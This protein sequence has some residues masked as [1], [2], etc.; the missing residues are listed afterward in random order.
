MVVLRRAL[1][2]VAVFVP[3]A[4]A[5]ADAASLAGHWEGAIHAPVE[6]VA[7]AVD[8]AADASGTL[9]GTFSNPAQKLNGYPLFSASSDGEVV[10]LELK[11]AG[12]GVQ[13]FAGRLSTDGE[14]ITGEFLID[15]HAVPFTLKRNGDARIVEVPKSAAIDAKLAGAWRGSLD[16]GGQSL[17]LA[18]T[19]TNHAD[20][21]AT[22]TWSAGGAPAIPIAIGYESGTL[23]LTSPI[24]PASFTGTLNAEGT[25]ISGTLREGA[26]PRAVVFTRV[27]NGG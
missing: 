21:T 12:P 13:T 10:K 26:A 3:G 18:L 1:T 15:V 27:G 9:A 16:V 5:A 19:M 6:D 24:T 7:V 14:T 22:G 4:W 8:V 23:T 20:R 25:A 2:V 11:T 17:P